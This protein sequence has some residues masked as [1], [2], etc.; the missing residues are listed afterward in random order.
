MPSEGAGAADGWS[1][2]EDNFGVD[3][4]DYDDLDEDGDKDGDFFAPLQGMLNMHDTKELVRLAD[5]A[6][7]AEFV[8]EDDHI[9]GL[10][11]SHIDRYLD[12]GD[13]DWLLPTSPVPSPEQRPEEVVRIVLKALKDTQPHE[14]H[15]AA[16]ALRFSLPLAKSE[17]EWEPPDPWRR[18]MR[19]AA[20]PRMFARELKDSN[21]RLWCDWALCEV[22]ELPPPPADST[23]SGSLQ[24]VKSQ[25][26]E[27][28]KNDVQMKVL[29]IA[30]DGLKLSYTATLGKASVSETGVWLIR[31]VCE[32]REDSFLSS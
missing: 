3:D 25:T 15:G 5:Q 26:N 30:P 16:V 2:N 27:I 6:A 17:L 19:R 29:L 9:A 28:L 4:Y 24:T 18:M 23:G 20:N 13:S 1:P 7:L 31:S 10:L 8:D 12:G 21:L 11:A 14:A 22:H 32:R